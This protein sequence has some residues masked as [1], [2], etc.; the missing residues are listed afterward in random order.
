MRLAARGFRLAAAVAAFAAVTIGGLVS[1][2]P[3]EAV[4]PQ[5]DGD[6]EEVGDLAVR[7]NTNGSVSAKRFDCISGSCAGSAWT[8][9]GGFVTEAKV[10]AV[11]KGWFVILGRGADGYYWFR[12]ANCPTSQLCT[13]GPWSSTR[14][15]GHDANLAI[16]S[17][18][19]LELAV[20]GADKGVWFTNL[21]TWG[22]GGWQ[23]LGG[24]VTDISFAGRNVFAVDP[25]NRLW[26]QTRESNGE[27]SRTWNG[28]GGYVRWPVDLGLGSAPAEFEV[29][30]VGG[31][32][33]IWV[34][35]SDSGWSKPPLLVSNVGFMDVSNGALPFSVRVIQQNLTPHVC[36]GVG[37]L[38]GAEWCDP[39]GGKVT[40]FANLWDSAEVSVA[41][42]TDGKTYYKVDTGGWTLL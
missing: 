32:N 3:A 4:Q 11:D 39:L 16:S 24:V 8:N 28:L 40:S 30:A 7:V 22:V 42:G 9:L 21:C 33:G 26:V 20:I 5:I 10:R 37:L 13:Y 36:S 31:D 15:F 34:Y 18:G 6:S 35:D 41:I 27:F 2:A 23:S 29:A 12:S 17:P 25:W 14:G 19:C 1:A 38:D